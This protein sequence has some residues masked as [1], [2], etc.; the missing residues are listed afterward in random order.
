MQAGTVN[1]KLDLNSLQLIAYG[2][3]AKFNLYTDD[4]ISKSY[5]KALTEITVEK[6]TAN[7]ENK[8]LSLEVL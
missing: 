1:R 8:Q 2:D 5:S 6:G 3:N 4:G 7:S